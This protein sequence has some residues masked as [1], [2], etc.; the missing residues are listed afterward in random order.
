MAMVKVGMVSRSKVRRNEQS[1]QR[2]KKTMKTR[3]GGVIGAI[4]SSKI[5]N[6]DRSYKPLQQRSAIVAII[7]SR[8]RT[9]QERGQ[10]PGVGYGWAENV[11][12]EKSG[13]RP[14]R[15]DVL[16]WAIYCSAREPCEKCVNP[17]N[18]VQRS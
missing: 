5:D 17:P 16:V 2:A 18:N 6:V 9:Q 7:N 4:G 10:C 13:E 12:E 3:S 14:P 11:A 1:K 8:E 15:G